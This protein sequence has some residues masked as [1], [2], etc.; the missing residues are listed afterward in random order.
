MYA[1]KA[2]VSDSPDNR[3]ARRRL[4]ARRKPGVAP[5][6]CGLEASGGLAA[7]C[8]RKVTPRWRR[9]SPVGHVGASMAPGKRGPAPREGTSRP[10]RFVAVAKMV[11][12]NLSRGVA[13][14]LEQ[15]GHAWR[16]KRCLA[17]RR[18]TAT[19]APP[20]LAFVI[21]RLRFARLSASSRMRS[22][23][24]AGQ[25]GVASGSPSRRSIYRS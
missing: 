13:V 15:F 12:A 3:R 23:A 11:L 6:S 4:L 24:P 1:A 14:R 20:Y 17:L 8:I 10:R 9:R 2:D 18:R 25:F 19:L 7:A 21:V 5:A 16:S 22:I